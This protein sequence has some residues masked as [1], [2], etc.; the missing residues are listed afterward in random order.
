MEGPMTNRQIP[1]L[2]MTSLVLSAAPVALTAQQGQQQDQ[3]QTQQQAQQGQYSGVSSPPQEEIITTTT[4]VAAPAAKPSAMRRTAASTGQTAQSAGGKSAGRDP[5][6][7]YPD[8]DPN[9]P[10]SNDQGNAVIVEDGQTPPAQQ[11]R[12]QQRAGQAGTGQA[13]ARPYVQP[14]QQNQAVPLPAEPQLVQRAKNYDPD[15]DIVHPYVA[16]GTLRE[17]TTLRVKLL[18]RL[19]TADTQKGEPFHTRVATDVVQGEQVLIPAGSLLDG[20]VSG[21]S[22]GSVGSHGTMNLHPETITLPDG[23]KY[24]LYAQLT[25]TP[26]THTHVSTEG[27]VNPDPR[28]K[29]DSIEYGGAVG[30]GVVAGAYLGGPA[31]MLAGAIVGASLVTVHLMVNHQQATLETGT[32]LVFSLTQPLTMQKAPV[33]DDS[34]Q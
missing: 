26:A 34:G 24:R 13:A 8:P 4:P 1:C 29:R 15:G 25:A 10:Q 2:I 20:H 32:T 3:P 30:T 27:T 21:I 31:G 33:T 18:D 6:L 22:S 9:M 19:S 16:P 12:N 23:T 28:I 7:D 14:G 11:V 17:G 5:L